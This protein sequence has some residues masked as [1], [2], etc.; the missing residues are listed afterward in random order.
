MMAA[1]ITST[2]LPR[3]SM[4]SRIHNGRMPVIKWLTPRGWPEGQRGASTLGL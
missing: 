1:T 4:I 3:N 2:N